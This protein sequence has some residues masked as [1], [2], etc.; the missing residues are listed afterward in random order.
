M[1]RLLREI[2]E[3]RGEL[4]AGFMGMVSL[5]IIILSIAGLNSIFAGEGGDAI[6]KRWAKRGGMITTEIDSVF[7]LPRTIVFSD[8]LHAYLPGTIFKVDIEGQS[9]WT[10]TLK[11]TIFGVKQFP[12]E[13]EEK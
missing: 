3:I 1:K 8:S 4:L 5:C 13:G 6:I 12:K 2:Y 7:A 11:D 9:G 10:Y